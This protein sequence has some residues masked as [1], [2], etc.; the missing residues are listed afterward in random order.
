MVATETDAPGASW[1]PA[2]RGSQPRS[3]GA[4]GLPVPPVPHSA[5]QVCLHLRLLVCPR[6]ISLPRFLRVPKSGN[7]RGGPGAAVSGG[8]GAQVRPP[9]PWGSAEG[10]AVQAA[11]F[12][13]ARRGPTVRTG[14]VTSAPSTNRA[15]PRGEGPAWCLQAEALRPTRGGR[16]GHRRRRVC[17]GLEAA[18]QYS[19]LLQTR[20]AHAES[21]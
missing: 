8:A 16:G 21:V 11:G 5:G 17:P 20:R 15:A 19:E 10:S 1:D 18:G 4:A 14:A 2:P 9:A 12:E 7:T 6:E 13:L 3:P